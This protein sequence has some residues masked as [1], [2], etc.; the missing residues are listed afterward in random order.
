MKNL[1]TKLC[2]RLGL[3]KSENLVFECLESERRVADI[4]QLTDLPRMTVTDILKRFLKREL[5][6]K[7][8]VGKQKYYKLANGFEL[9]K[10]EIQ[11]NEIEKVVV[12]RGEDE[13]F[14]TWD[15][16]SSNKNAKWFVYQPNNAVEKS[17]PK[18]DI[19]KLISVNKKSQANKIMVDGYIEKG[20]IEA[21]EK[22]I[23]K[24]LLPDWKKSIQR[25]SIVREV[26]KQVFQTPYEIFMVHNI[27]YI[28]DWDKNVS[29]EIHQA[30]LV[31]ILKQFFNLLHH[32]STRIDFNRKL[33]YF[34]KDSNLPLSCPV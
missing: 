17:L 32:N 19:Q 8:K 31:N 21:A 5:V 16:L 12:H 28:N 27:V 13:L 2:K 24:E 25:T 9:Q 23:P 10:P 34:S 18:I 7:T 14:K 11:I 29:I 15:R 6:E 3:T 1:N 4:I 20:Y 26:D 30:E 22:F 33:S